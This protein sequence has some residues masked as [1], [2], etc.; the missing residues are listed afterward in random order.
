MIFHFRMLRVC[1]N[2]RIYHN[3]GANWLYVHFVSFSFMFWSM[4]IVS[5][6]FGFAIGYVSTLQIQVTSP[7]THNVSGTAK[8]AAQTVLAVL[9][10]HEIR[11]ISWWLSNAIVVFASGAYAYVRHRESLN[12]QHQP[13]HDNSS[14]EKGLNP[15]PL[16]VEH[17]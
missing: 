14:I 16:K 6:I 12:K 13:S 9:I 4:M 15:P 17:Q 3:A 2:I 8:A 7:L 11:S 1:L 10:Y 5:G